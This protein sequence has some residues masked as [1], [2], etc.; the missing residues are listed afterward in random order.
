MSK[1]VFI[2]QNSPEIR[3]KLEQAGFTVCACASFVDSVWLDYH[4]E[5]DFYRDIHG[6]GHT[7]PESWEEKYSPLEII[8][9]RLE[10]RYVF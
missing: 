5:G 3:E 1:I 10:K 8:Q 4:P 9:I 6:C 7:Y 2:T